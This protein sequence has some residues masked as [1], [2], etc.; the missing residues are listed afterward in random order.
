[1]NKTYYP[2]LDETVLRETLPN[3]LRLCIV[4]KPQH[5]KKYAFFAAHYGGMDVRFSLDGEKFDT[6]AGIAHYLEHKMFDTEEGNALQELAKNGAEPNAFTSNEI[7]AYYFDCTE[8]FEEN[9]RILLSFVSVPYFTAESVEKERGIIGQEIRMVEDNP[10]WQVY[11]QMMQLLYKEHPARIPVA[12]SVESIADITPE[13][14]YACHK[15]FYAPG[16]MVLCVVGDVNAD[17]VR[18]IAMEILPREQGASIEREHGVG[19]TAEA[20]QAA[21]SRRMEVSMPQFLSGFKCEAPCKGE[22]MMRAVLIGDMACDVLLGDSSALYQRLYD[23]QLINGSFG[24][25]FDVLSGAAYLYAGGDS[26]DPQRV[27]DEILAEAARIARE[28]VDETLYQ[29]TRRAGFGQSLRALN[30]FESIAVSLAEG[31]FRGF[32]PNRFPELY[33]SI[34]KADI[35]AFIRE[36]IVA[37]RA[38]L[39]VIEPKEDGE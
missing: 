4:P 18:E 17:R 15:A 16:N 34:E 24:A 14:L 39:S 21:Q 3:G 10:E 22:E 33:D 28:G 5:V 12:G 11:E 38:V 37:E 27:H 29:Q 23:A 31:T 8:H 25:S 7:T 1:M 32:D 2:R 26:N 30:S 19:E 6:P 20:A 36:N 13:L 35:E 9:L